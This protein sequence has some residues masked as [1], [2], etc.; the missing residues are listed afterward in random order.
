MKTSYLPQD[1][2][3]K[4]F[5]LR[6]CYTK[7]LTND[8]DQRYDLAVIVETLSLKTSWWPK[9]AILKSQISVSLLKTCLKT[10]QKSIVL[11]LKNIWLLR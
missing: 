1:G 5:G 11:G 3:S 10:A 7:R 9:Q 4:H 8:H 2:I 6:Y